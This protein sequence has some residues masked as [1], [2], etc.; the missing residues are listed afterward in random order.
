MKENQNS[1]WCSATCTGA[2][3][4][5]AAE[6]SARRWVKPADPD[7]GRCVSGLH[8]PSAATRPASRRAGRGSCQDLVLHSYAADVETQFRKLFAIGRGRAVLALAAVE[9]CLPDPAPHRVHRDLELLGDLTASRLALG[10][11]WDMP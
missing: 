5:E 3:V 6:E 7:A 2:K 8:R 9:L 1:C 4:T 10:T 11:P